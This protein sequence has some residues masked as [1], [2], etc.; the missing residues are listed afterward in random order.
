M[1]Q[2]TGGETGR[3]DVALAAFRVPIDSSG[4]T[5]VV[6]TAQ[7][8]GG[9]SFKLFEASPR[10]SR[11]LARDLRRASGKPALHH[12]EIALSLATMITVMNWTN[13]TTTGLVARG[14]TAFLVGMYL[15][16]RSQ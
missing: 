9:E 11:V 3:N 12:L 5:K 1:E 16:L 8:P 15:T 2:D 6:V 10:E 4:A 7:H 13:E 14:A